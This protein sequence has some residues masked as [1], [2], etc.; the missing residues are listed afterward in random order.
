[1]KAP[2]PLVTLVTLGSVAPLGG[3]DQIKPGKSLGANAAANG[4][5]TVN[6]PA[7]PLNGVY[8]PSVE[9]SGFLYVSG[10]N[11]QT[12]NESL[13]GLS[14]AE[15]TEK[16]LTLLK[17]TLA[18]KGYSFADVVEVSIALAKEEDFALFNAAYKKQFINKGARY[19]AR[20][21]GLGVLHQDIGALVEITM[22]A[23]KAP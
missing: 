10:Q 1:M 9:A 13:L 14:V 23:Y 4:D 17:A 6:K 21:T 19:P 11:A 15:Q 8:R 20:S 5:A 16:A 12:A 3:C 2:L 22:V 18:N 7:T